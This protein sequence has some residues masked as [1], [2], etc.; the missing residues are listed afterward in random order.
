MRSFWFSFTWPWIKFKV[1]LFKN[2]IFCACTRMIILQ[3]RCRLQKKSITTLCTKEAISNKDSMSQIN[4]EISSSLIGLKQGQ[5]IN[6]DRRTGLDLK[7]KEHNFSLTNFTSNSNW[8]FR[9]KII[10]MIFLIAF[11]WVFLL[12]YFV[13]D[14]RNTHHH[15][16][17]ALFAKGV[18]KYRKYKKYH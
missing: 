4:R 10:L 8:T 13:E 5:I 15:R 9:I 18:T 14:Q 6:W 11:L 17:R 2:Q 16:K 3:Y 12:L 1:V 7:K